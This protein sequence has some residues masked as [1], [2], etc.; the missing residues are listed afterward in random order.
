MATQVSPSF[1]IAGWIKDPYAKAD[2]LMACFYATDYSQS[3]EWL[4]KLHSLPSILQRAANNE[5]ELRSIITSSLKSLFDAHY[6]NS[7][8]EVTVVD[9]SAEGGSEAKLNIIVRVIFS[10]SNVRMSLGRALSVVNGKFSTVT[11][12]EKT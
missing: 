10:Q 4:G 8:V 7:N 5:I 11:N 1:T 2:N 9:E 6:D 3:R 12:L